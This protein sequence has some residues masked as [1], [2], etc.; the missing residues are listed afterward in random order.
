MF[1]NNSKKVPVDV[2]CNILAFVL[3]VENS[4]PNKTAMLL[5]EI[6]KSPSPTDKS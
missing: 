1:V 4:L 2:L 3:I 6:N 5:K